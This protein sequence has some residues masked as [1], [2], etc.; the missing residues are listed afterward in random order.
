MEARVAAPDRG[1]YI[2]P[3][4][5]EV[6]RRAQGAGDGGVLVAAAGGRRGGRRGA[7]RPA[8]RHLKRHLVSQ[9]YER[10]TSQD[11]A[12]W[13]YILRRAVRLLSERA[14]PSYL[15]GLR[16][17]GIGTE[18]I[19]RIEEMNEILSRLGWAA[20]CVD[21]FIPP[22]AFME[23]QAH[24]VLVIAADMRQ[25]GHVAYT[26]APDIV[27]EA[28]GHAPIIVDR[29][30]AEYL[31]RIGEVGA[32]AMSS[33]ADFELY[34]AIRRLSQVKEQRGADPEA[35][36]RAEREVAERQRGLGAPSEMALVSRLHWWTV[37]YGLVGPLERP[38]IYG[39]GLLS[40]LGEA[41]TCLGP[42]VR[43]LPYT[44]EA[45]QV[46]YDITRKQ[47]QLFVTPDFERLSEVSCASRRGCLA[48][49]G[50]EAEKPVSAEGATA[51]GAPARVCGVFRSPTRRRG[52][53]A[54]ALRRPPA[55]P[56]G[57]QL[58]QAT[59]TARLRGDRGALAARRS[60][61]R[62]EPGHARGCRSHGWSSKARS[63]RRGARRRPALV[64]RGAR[65]L[66]TSP[67]P[68]EWGDFDCRGGLSR[69]RRAA[70]RTPKHRARLAQRTVKQPTEAPGPHALYA[71]GGSSA[72]RAERQTRRSG[73]LQARHTDD[74]LLPLELLELVREREPGSALE[75]ELRGHLA[76]RAR[77]PG[78]GTLVGD[79][80]ECR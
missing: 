62:P 50:L 49:G 60:G 63:Q 32:R 4:A 37:E 34:E 20:A 15:E 25:V 80:L 56:A 45:A 74:W 11:H 47:P 13:R 69:L 35:L 61:S 26:P 76:R 9:G 48:V 54:I 1:R 7:A 38:R 58:P 43:K 22:A 52:R 5:C 64:T 14:H 77:E 18:R 28:A 75:R 17:T 68:S 29:A 42:E 78:L 79:G 71:R 65:S 33:R 21:G 16:A 31:R 73:R 23:L 24:R 30:Y 59:P 39:A 19:P 67:L 44:L 10:Y 53:L 72:S 66:G 12:V 2:D 51:V 3:K 57:Q 27:H 36:A 41:E 70:T 6:G 8:A 46:A 55:L 40:S